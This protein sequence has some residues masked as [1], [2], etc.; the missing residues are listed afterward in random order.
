MKRMKHGESRKGKH[1]PEYDAWRSMISRCSTLS[2]PNAADYWGRG[3]KICQEWRESYPAFLACVGRR[4]SRDH[5]LDR[6]PNNDGNYEPG[7]V[8]WATKAEQAANRRK[9]VHRR[10]R[11]LPEIDFGTVILYKSNSMADEHILIAVQ[12]KKRKGRALTMAQSRSITVRGLPIDACYKV[13]NESFKEEIESSKIGLYERPDEL[14]QVQLQQYMRDPASGK[15]KYQ[16]SKA[17]TVPNVG[18][19]AALRRIKAAFSQPKK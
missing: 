8:R 5:S 10:K 13:L 9:G 18:L 1:S 14:V 4:P 15:L 19:Q 3:I 12:H 2:H 16:I 7:N 6:Y 11:V 17:M